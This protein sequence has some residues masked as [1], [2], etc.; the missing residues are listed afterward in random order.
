[1]NMPVQERTYRSVVTPGALAGY[2]VRV[3]ETDLQV[4]SPTAMPDLVRETVLEVR[5]HL[6]GYIQRHPAFLTTLTPWEGR[7]PAPP[8]VQTMIRAG[9]Q[10]GVGPMAAVAGAVAQAAGRALLEH[11]PQAIV[12]NGGDIFLR[13]SGPALIA[14][15]AGKSPLNLKI[16]LRLDT[17]SAPA[18]VCTSSGTVGH[19][20]SLGRADAVCVVSPDAALADAAA[21]AL[22]NRVRRAA[23][24]DAALAHGRR[25]PG[26]EG[27]VIICGTRIGAW[28]RVELVPLAPGFGGRSN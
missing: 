11:G 24:I 3:R 15:H 1:M 2:R 8:L 9:R 17:R 21:T 23:D 20:L 25:I 19:S 4:Y 26:V 14:L 18:G 7:A 13:T 27:L 5:A 6:E 28:G 16:G 22:G 12:E 10:A